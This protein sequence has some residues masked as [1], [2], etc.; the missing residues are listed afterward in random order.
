MVRHSLYEGGG[1]TGPAGLYNKHDDIYIYILCIRLVC[2][3]CVCLYR[4]V[5]EIVESALRALAAI[6][7]GSFLAHILTLLAPGGGHIV[8]PCYVFAYFC[9]NTRTSSLKKL[10]FSQL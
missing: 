8:P 6:F 3:M 1:E 4:R 9:A 2:L 5:G 7:F 10:D